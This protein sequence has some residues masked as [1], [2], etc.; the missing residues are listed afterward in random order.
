MEKTVWR[1]VTN[2]AGLVTRVRPFYFINLIWFMDIINFITHTN[3]IA[4]PEGETRSKL[5]N[6][7]TLCGCPTSLKFH[8][9]LQVA[10][11]L[12][13]NLTQ[14]ETHICSQG[15][16]QGLIPGNCVGRQRTPCK[17]R[18]STLKILSLKFRVWILDLLQSKRIS[19]MDFD[20]FILQNKSFWN[21]KFRF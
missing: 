17:W 1:W 8:P 19:G 13:K 18:Y 16:W 21:L 11:S 3:F 14:C 2:S 20:A 12:Q 7:R 6:L 4:W 10:A 5:W 9:K 15:S